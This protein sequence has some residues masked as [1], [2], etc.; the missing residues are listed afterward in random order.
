MHVSTKAIRK[1]VENPTT[2]KECVAYLKSSTLDDTLAAVGLKDKAPEDYQRN[3]VRAKYFVAETESDM[4]A[5]IRIIESKEHNSAD[6]A[7]RVAKLD[8]QE[9]KKQEYKNLGDDYI[10]GRVGMTLIMKNYIRVTD[11]ELETYLRR[12]IP[13]SQKDSQTPAE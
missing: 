5:L 11:K 4:I 2:F 13:A 1:R 3:T 12:M 8:K 7:W 9:Y 6:T 10:Y